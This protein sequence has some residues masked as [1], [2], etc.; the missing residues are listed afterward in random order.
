MGDAAKT[1][2]AMI[3]LTG[4]DDASGVHLAAT[5]TDARKMPV[6]GMTVRFFELTKEFG[7]AG[8]LVPLGSAATDRSGVARLTDHPAVTGLQ[9]FVVTYPGGPQAG[10]ASASAGVMVTTAHSP[11]RPLPARPLASAGKGLVGVLLVTLALILLT[12]AI[13]VERVRR[14]CRAGG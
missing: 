3:R 8:Q 14:V 10:R 12:L 4:T 11:Y 7:P 2:P 1:K 5:L 13:Q 6:G 9:R